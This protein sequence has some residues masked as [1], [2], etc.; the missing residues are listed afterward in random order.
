[1]RE[2]FIQIKD[3]QPFEHPIARE[4]MQQLFPQHDLDT[5]T[6]DNFA[7]FE[8]KQP[9]LTGP[10]TRVTDQTYEWVNGIITDVFATRELTAEE[11]FA[12]QES[13]KLNFEKNIG[14]KSWVFDDAQCTMKAPIPY[15]GN[16]DG[17]GPRYRWNETTLEWN[18]VTDQAITDAQTTVVQE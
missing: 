3:G 14:Y 1:M 9:P 5:T 17:T 7:V 4:N 13:V 6:P 10:Y 16:Q 15:P 11:R 2:F 12:Q 8:R 18:D